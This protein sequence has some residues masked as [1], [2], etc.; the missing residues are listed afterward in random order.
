MTVIKSLA[1]D[2]RRLAIAA[3]RSFV[4]AEIFEPKRSLTNALLADASRDESVNARRT[5]ELAANTSAAKKSCEDNSEAD[6]A[7]APFT[8]ASSEARAITSD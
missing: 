3:K 7:L 5:D 6:D 8:A 2:Q 4:L 1:A